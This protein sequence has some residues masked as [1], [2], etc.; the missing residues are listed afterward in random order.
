MNFGTQNKLH[1]Y[2]VREEET[3]VNIHVVQTGDTLWT[4][5]Q[6]YGVSYQSIVGVNQLPSSSIVP[7]Q[8]LLIP[9]MT[10]SYVVMPG[11][12]LYLIAN[13]YGLSISE[14]LAWNPQIQESN[15]FIGDIIRLP[16]V[17]RPSK[18]ALGFLELIGPQIDQ[19]NVTTNAPYYS[20]LA[21]F[22]YGMTASGAIT[23][24]QDESALQS[25]KQ[26]RAIPTAT[27]ANWTQNQFSRNAVHVMLSTA[28]LRQQYISEVIRIVHEKGY[29]AVA[30]DF[31][32][33][34]SEDRET[35]VEFLRELS[36]QLQPLGIPSIVC[37][38]PITGHLPYESPIVEAY[39]YASIAQN[40]TFIMLMSYNW[41]WPGGPPGPVASLPLV[42]DN[43]NYALQRM[44]RRQILLGLI[45]YGYDWALPYQPG[46]ATGTWNVQAV[47]EMAM[48][49]QIPIQFDAQSLTPWL[50]YWNRQG[51]QHIIWFEDAR[52]LQLKLQLVRKHQLAGMAAWELSERFPQFTQLVLD[53]FRIQ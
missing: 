22:T 32:S 28:S 10:R 45:R 4:I 49:N 52:S 9:V 23:P 34:L 43:I 36:A 5:S 8:T 35:F 20:Y 26:T 40:A 24:A 31:E 47:V 13:R 6:Q 2:A 44:S 42:E 19:A 18:T 17:A 51:R 29:K 16:V 39:D 7:G 12:S 48:Q 15:I 25:V 46:E 27:F 3:T 33:L 11:D 50:R 37:A 30:I 1:T 41:S 53:S 21:L 14:L 38:M